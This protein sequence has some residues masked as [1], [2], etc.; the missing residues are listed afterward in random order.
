VSRSR[1]LATAI[2]WLTVVAGPQRVSGPVLR[3]TD[4]WAL[5]SVFKTIASLVHTR[6][7]LFMGLTR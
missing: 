1:P 3:V 5:V 6:A 7:A 4:R 2:Q